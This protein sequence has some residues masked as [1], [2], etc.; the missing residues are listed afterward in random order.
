MDIHGV[1]EV[2]L[3]GFTTLKSKIGGHEFLKCRITQVISF[4]LIL[5]CGTLFIWTVSKILTPDQWSWYWKLIILYF[6]PPAGKET[7]LPAGLGVITSLGVGVK[8]PAMIWG[9]SIWILD[10]LVCL[11]ILTNWWLL[12]FFINHIPGFP[13]IGIRRNP[14][15]IYRTTVSLKQWY[16]NLHR[17]TRSIVAKRYGR[18][19]PVALLIFMFVPFQGTGAMSTTILGTLIGF[20]NR[21]TFLTVTIGSFISTSLIILVSSGFLK[22][23]S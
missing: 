14:P 21:E 9:L 19:L 1:K 16:N 12:E 15:R 5:V 18:L 8:L 7:V 11:A 3:V 23:V 17:R 20:R 13:F 10:L 22:I 6:I 4:F 2:E